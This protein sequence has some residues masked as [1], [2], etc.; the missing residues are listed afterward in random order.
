M[1]IGVYLGVLAYS[2]RSLALPI[3]VHFLNN[4][5]AVV[6]MN[7][8]DTTSTEMPDGTPLWIAAIIAAIIIIIAMNKWDLCLG[9]LLC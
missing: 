1:I 3:T 9:G 7:L 6:A 4:A 2:T 5:I 8:V